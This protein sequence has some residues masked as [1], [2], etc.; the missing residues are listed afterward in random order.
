MRA[1]LGPRPGRT[2]GRRRRCSR[3]W[4]SG[5]SRLLS[6]V[7]CADVGGDM[8][9]LRLEDALG[10]GVRNVHFEVE[11]ALRQRGRRPRRSRR[12]VTSATFGSSASWGCRHDDPEGHG[13]RDPALTDAEKLL[14]GTTASLVGVHHSVVERVQEQALVGRPERAPRVSK[15]A[16][17]H[18]LLCEKVKEYPTICASRLGDDGAR[19]GL[20]R[21]RPHC[22]A[23]RARSAS[24]EVAAGRTWCA[25]GCRASRRRS[26]GGTWVASRWRE[27]FAPSGSS[28][29]T[30]RTRACVCRVGP[31]SDG[32]IA[33]SVAGPGRS[34]SS[35]DRRASGSSTMPR[36]WCSSATAARRGC[37]PGYSS[38]GLASG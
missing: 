15:L 21:Q 28:S 1:V 14:P 3:G 19:A 23:L 7:L 10:F 33:S 18:G 36:P 25:S 26:T 31:G 16:P 11:V 27:A 37:T 12:W 6:V 17:Y 20:R 32:R 35:A 38:C 22:A 5:T 24:G 9:P 4:R 29:C 34:R 2:R 8:S 30:W 13:A